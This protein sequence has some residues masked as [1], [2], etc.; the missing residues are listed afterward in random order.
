MKY[1]G[2]IYNDIVATSGL[3]LTLFVQGCPHHCFGCH[4]ADTWDFDGGMEFSIDT[5]DEILTNLNAQGIKRNFCLMGGEP[6]C[7]ENVFLSNLVIS[8]IKEESP[9][10]PIYV[11]T[12]YTLEELQK[13]N[14]PKVN[15][16]LNTIDCLIDGPY[17]AEERDI[18]L[19]MRGSRNQKIYYLKETRNGDEKSPI[20]ENP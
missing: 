5:L 2:I 19:E 10:T 9:D 4:N 1:S 20:F 18:T 16:I 7:D 14:N 11:W 17:K 15:N 3:S 8:V 12:G 13:R 6:L